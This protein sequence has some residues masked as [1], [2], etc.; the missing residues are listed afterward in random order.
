MNQCIDQNEQLKASLVVF[1]QQY[2]VILTQLYCMQYFCSPCCFGTEHSVI[3]I[4]N[5]YCLEQAAKGQF[6]LFFF[7]HNQYVALCYITCIIP[8]ATL[9]QSVGAVLVIKLFIACNGQLKL[10]LA[11]LFIRTVLF[12]LICMIL[13][14]CPTLELTVLGHF[15]N[16]SGPEQVNDSVLLTGSQY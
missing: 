10:S 5:F 12:S 7:F 4:I 1:F 16:G 13:A 3:L 9:E 2:Y 15:K 8:C 11:G 6:G 14:G